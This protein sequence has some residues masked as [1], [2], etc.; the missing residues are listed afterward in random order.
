M[1]WKTN[2]GMALLGAMLAAPVWA[3]HAA[4]G[5]IS[6]DMWAE[7]DDR[8]TDMDSPHLDISFDE[9]LASMYVDEAADGGQ[10]LLVSS[11][12]HEVLEE[13]SDLYGYIQTAL[14]EIKADWIGGEG[15]YN[16]FALIEL[17]VDGCTFSLYEPIGSIGWSDEYDAEDAEEIFYC[18]G[19]D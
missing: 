18:G 15:N 4:E 14:E 1:K 10:L 16:N 13:C 7:I 2:L 3:H 17:V 11:Y 9:M 12:T 19:K 6:D 8:L 5:I